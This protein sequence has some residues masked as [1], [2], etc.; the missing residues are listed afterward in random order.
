[1]RP[2]NHLSVENA[3]AMI[4]HLFIRKTKRKLK[5]EGNVVKMTCTK[6]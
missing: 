4:Q 5:L 2:H 1:M 3:I 6:P